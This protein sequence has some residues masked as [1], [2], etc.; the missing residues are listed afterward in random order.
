MPSLSYAN[1]NVHHKSMPPQ[2]TRPRSLY[3]VVKEL[4]PQ[5]GL[6]V[7]CLLCIYRVALAPTN[8]SREMAPQW[9]EKRNLTSLLSPRLSVASPLPSSMISE[10]PKHH[11]EQE[12]MVTAWSTQ[13]ARRVVRRRNA[14]LL[15]HKIIQALSFLFALSVVYLALSKGISSLS[16]PVQRQGHLRGRKVWVHSD[17][18]LFVS[19]M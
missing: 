3:E 19:C 8:C 14:S 9:R 12:K 6:S 7:F 5:T 2:N 15:Q 18:Q 16:Q 17:S 13:T 4:V 11:E 1:V 10:R